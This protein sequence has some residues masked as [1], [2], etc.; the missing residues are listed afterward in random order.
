[1]K[2]PNTPETPGRVAPACPNAG[3]N[4]RTVAAGSHYINLT[5]T[6]LGN[7]DHR[8]L[9]GRDLRYWL[10]H[11]LNTQ[12]QTDHR[13]TDLA[14]AVAEQGFTLTGRPS[15][16]LSDALHTETDRGRITRTGWGR[17]Q[18]SR[19]L[20][21]TTQWRITKRLR[22][23]HRHIHSIILQA[24]R[25]IEDHWMNALKPHGIRAFL[26]PKGASR[27]LQAHIYVMP[28]KSRQPNEKHRKPAPNP[29]TTPPPDPQ[30]SG[31]SAPETSGPA[32]HE[33]LR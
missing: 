7:P 5:P 3:P 21:P 2:Q 4:P 14:V 8:A 25:T 24:Q 10:L 23:L 33:Y 22:T 19:P 31:P 17:Y 1:M 30:A 11:H 32:R 20:A 13:I 26:L 29:P 9:H 16:T 18:I 27:R 12:P 28:H 6:D 15:K